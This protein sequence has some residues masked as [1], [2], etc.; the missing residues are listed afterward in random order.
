MHFDGLEPRLR[1]A[2]FAIYRSAPKCPY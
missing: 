1:A 2:R